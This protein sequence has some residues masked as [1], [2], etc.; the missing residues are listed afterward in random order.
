MASSRPRFRELTLILTGNTQDAD[1]L[2]IPQE[3]L[4]GQK[5]AG[6]IGGRLEVGRDLYSDL[7]N[8]YCL[9]TNNIIYD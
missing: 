9:E 8:M 3:A 2:S 7:Q 4:G 5:R 1:V 6:M